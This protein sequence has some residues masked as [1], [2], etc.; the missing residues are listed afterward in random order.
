MSPLTKQKIRERREWSVLRRFDA[1]W[2]SN[3]II[4]KVANSVV[5]SFFRF[6]KHICPKFK[7]ANTEKTMT[8]IK[9]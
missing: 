7:K 1:S 8:K 9:G 3:K 6:D 4:G 5:T 2:G